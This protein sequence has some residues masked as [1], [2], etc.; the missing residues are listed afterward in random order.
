MEEKYK[1]I[2]NEEKK[3]F[4]QRKCNKILVPRIHKNLKKSSSALFYFGNRNLLGSKEQPH[5]KNIEFDSPYEKL[6]FQ[7]YEGRNLP[8]IMTKFIHP[9]KSNLPLNQKQMIKS[10]FVFNKVKSKYVLVKNKIFRPFIA[11]IHNSLNDIE[12]NRFYNSFLNKTKSQKSFDNNYKNKNSQTEKPEFIK[13]EHKKLKKDLIQSI[14]IKKE[15]D[16]LKERIP[17]NTLKYFRPQLF[18]HSKKIHKKIIGNKGRQ[19]QSKTDNKKNN[20]NYSES[21]FTSQNTDNISIKYEIMDINNKKNY[22]AH[23]LLRR[24]T[25]S[26]F[27]V[28]KKKEKSDFH[29]IMKH[30]FSDN[31]FCSTFVNHR[32]FYNNNSY[33]NDYCEKF[34][35]LN[36][37]LKDDDL[38]RK[39]HNLIINPNT[40]KIRNSKLL[41]MYKNFPKGTFYGSKNNTNN[42][43]LIDEELK[44]LEKT[45]YGKFVNKLNQTM[46]KVKEMKK[47]LNEELFINK[48]NL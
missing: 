6:N 40:N 37:P 34:Q 3:N 13:L 2:S 45:K 20:W 25:S 39:L 7:K 21:S 38:I 16:S 36:N 44:K 26:P 1:Y 46:Q 33:T 4:L 41:L 24:K 28:F 11:T 15:D 43:L 5:I 27:Y 18:K 19:E 35:K 14:N 23:K 10:I 48:N 29:F 8:K 22:I 42:T 31:F 9:N 47:E 17:I 32:T 30:P 12:K